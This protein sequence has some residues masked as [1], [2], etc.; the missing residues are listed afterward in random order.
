MLFNGFN[1][2]WS[3]SKV[4]SYH[5]HTRNVASTFLKDL[6]MIYWLYMSVQFLHILVL[7]AWWLDSFQR[8]P[9]LILSPR[10]FVLELPAL[11]EVQIL[12]SHRYTCPVSCNGSRKHQTFS[13]G[14]SSP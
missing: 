8:A 1:F 3:I 9:H 2:F 10:L 5:T 4:L 14:S 13:G 11:F 6:Y 12:V 7:S